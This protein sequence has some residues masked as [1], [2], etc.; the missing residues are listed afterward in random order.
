MM[1]KNE[2]NGNITQYQFDHVKDEKSSQSQV[3]DSI[4]KKIIQDVLRGYNGTILAYG[5]TG[6][7]KTYTIF[8]DAEDEYGLEKVTET[9]GILTRAV[10]DI[11]EF[12]ESKKRGIE[13]KVSFIQIYLNKISDLIPAEDEDED[14]PVD[15]DNLRFM[16]TKGIIGLNEVKVE[17]DKE[18][19]D[20]VQRGIRSRKCD[21]TSM[22]ENSSRSHA[23]LKIHVNQILKYKNQENAQKL[24]GTFTLVDLAGSESLSNIESNGQ[25]A[26]E[27]KQEIDKKALELIDLL[28]SNND[29]KQNENKSM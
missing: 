20:Y 18:L 12:K 26:K 16:Q 27:A 24:S 7:G 9:S 15:H 28:N 4:G 2:N 21:S 13:I 1:Q 25:I 6:T 5:Q 10:Q 17:S 11:F 19:L 8:G 22:N 23:I 3:Y 14:N 29:S